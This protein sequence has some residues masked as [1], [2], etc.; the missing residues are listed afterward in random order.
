M[1]S[2]KLHKCH[3]C[4]K[5]FNETETPS[6]VLLSLFFFIVSMDK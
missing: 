4:I 1:R 6:F 3:T 5:G 2:C